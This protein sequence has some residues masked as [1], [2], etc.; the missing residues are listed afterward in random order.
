MSHW[1]ISQHM[2]AWLARIPKSDCLPDS[3]FHYP[4]P[5][6]PA[7]P[8]DSYPPLP[9]GRT[10]SKQI[11]VVPGA[12]LYSLLAFYLFLLWLISLPLALTINW[13]SACRAAVVSRLIP[14]PQKQRC[15]LE[16][17]CDIAFKVKYEQLKG[18]LPDFIRLSHLNIL[19]LL[20]S[21]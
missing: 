17:Y 1:L 9:C 10:S 16:H 3:Q 13:T 5:I 7:K 6:K 12:G 8:S 14:L 19:R 15:C 4:A 21:V 20:S 11:C 18:F 2:G